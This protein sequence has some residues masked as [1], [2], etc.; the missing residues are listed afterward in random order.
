MWSPRQC[1]MSPR[2]SCPRAVVTGTRWL[3]RALSCVGGRQSRLGP[4]MSPWGRGQEPGDQAPPQ[5]AA[6]STVA[7]PRQPCLH[8]NNVP[9]VQRP[10]PG[11]H[12]LVLAPPPRDFLARGLPATLHLQGDTLGHGDKGTGFPPHLAGSSCAS[13]ACPSP[14][15]PRS[16]GRAWRG[17]QHPHSLR[18]GL[19]CQ[20]H[21][22]YP[23][24]SRPG[25]RRCGQRRPPQRTS[26]PARAV[27]A[28]PCS[29]G[30]AKSCQ[31]QR[32]EKAHG[33]W[34]HSTAQHSW[35]LLPAPFGAQVPPSLKAWGGGWS[36]AGSWAA[37]RRYPGDTSLGTQGPGPGMLQLVGVSAFSC[38]VA[39]VLGSPS[40]GK[41]AAAAGSWLG[42]LG[43]CGGGESGC[44]LTLPL[45]GPPAVSQIWGPKPQFSTS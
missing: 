4:F 5:L 15:C 13:Q 14:S 43:G 44:L 2:L 29:Q 17:P 22:E 30:L 37:L 18:A 21:P 23:P 24:L 39:G 40:Q 3:W 35:W 45:K 9:S 12:Y 10:K 42:R 20:S 32:G 6:L 16:L 41:V 38:C 7:R 36:A 27:P 26:S 31:V 28:Q 19:R 8:P 25:Q 11:T 33:Q 34:P 1:G